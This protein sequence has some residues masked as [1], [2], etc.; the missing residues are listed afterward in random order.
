MTNYQQKRRLKS[1]LI[2][3]FKRS[4]SVPPSRNG[5]H[6][7]IEDSDDPPKFMHYSSSDEFTEQKSLLNPSPTFSYDSCDS[8]PS[9]IEAKND[10][11]FTL[12]KMD[13][14][15]IY[16]EISAAFQNMKEF[17]C[18]VCDNIVFASDSC[19]VE[20]KLSKISTTF[21]NTMKEKL[22]FPDHLNSFNRACYDVSSFSQLLDGIMLSKN[23]L[24]V[25]ASN[26]VIITFCKSCE[27]NISNNSSRNP[28]KFAIANGL[29]IGWFPPN[30]DDTTRTEHVMMNLAQS[31]KFFCHY[32]YWR[33]LY[34]K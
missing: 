18:A 6:S 19:L 12:S 5:Y 7:H 33:L 23:G 22:V 20:K 14:K 29:W 2:K 17:V 34:I 9:S 8:T 32:C 21:L 25:N 3:N 31:I 16:S 1:K 30:F 27:K 26:D 4:K 28:P 13:E 11:I 10:S 15:R 24:C